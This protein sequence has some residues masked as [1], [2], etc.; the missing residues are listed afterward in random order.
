MSTPKSPSLAWEK[1]S[2]PSRGPKPTLTRMQIARA[3]MQLA[4]AEGLDAV[5]MERV[6]GEMGV[7]TMALYRYFP[8][9]ADLIDRMIDS[10]SDAPDCSP[11]SLTWSDRLKEWAHRCL[12]I[13]RKH[14]WLMQATSARHSVMG[15]NELSWME[16]ALAMLAESGLAPGDRHHAFLAIIGHVRGFATFPTATKEGASARPWIRDLERILQSEGDRFPV[17]LDSLRS[18]AFAESSDA[19]FDFGLDCI[20]EGIR[21]KAGRRRKKASGSQSGGRVPPYS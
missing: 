5:T 1:E 15:P 2:T 11:S 20:L 12:L 14:P 21:A 3:A 18:G 10:A 6:A 8:G 19:A 16:A 13:Y 7:T 4:D 9:K 17:L